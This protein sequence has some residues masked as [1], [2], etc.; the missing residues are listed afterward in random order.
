MSMGT[1]HILPTCVSR[2]ID[3]VSQNHYQ[4]IHLLLDYVLGAID[5][6]GL[7]HYQTRLVSP[8]GS[9]QNSQRFGFF[10]DQ[11]VKFEDDPSSPKYDFFLLTV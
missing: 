5:F 10:E 7:N 2:P 3:F 11:D 4:T 1:I 9:A 8:L 6:V